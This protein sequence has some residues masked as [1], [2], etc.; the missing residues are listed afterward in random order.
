M[1]DQASIPSGSDFSAP[2]KGA[3]DFTQDPVWDLVA[4]DAHRYPVPESPWFAA[5]TSAM[6]LQTPQKVGFFPRISFHS[7][8]WMSIPLAGFAAIALLLHVITPANSRLPGSRSPLSTV[9]SN[10]SSEKL[11]EQHMEMLASSSSGDSSYQ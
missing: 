6:A 9:A 4:Q 11:F 1:S 8:W 10:V 7:R 3:E 2:E 5:R